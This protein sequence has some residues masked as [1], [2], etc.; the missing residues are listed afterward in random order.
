MVLKAASVCRVVMWTRCEALDDD[1]VSPDGHRNICRK[2]TLKKKIVRGNQSGYILK[3]S[4]R[5]A[6]RMKKRG[7]RKHSKKRKKKSRERMRKIR[8]H[9]QQEKVKVRMSYLTLN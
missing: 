5:T 7:K 4:R 2:V 9:R 1:A 8:N 6:K 3:H